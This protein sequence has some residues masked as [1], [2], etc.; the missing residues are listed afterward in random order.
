MNQRKNNRTEPFLK[1][2]TIK[3]IIAEHY[4]VIGRMGGLSKSSYKKVASRMNGKKGGR[5]FGSKNKKKISL[6]I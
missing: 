5:P 6:D 3:E 2:D 1:S 4:R